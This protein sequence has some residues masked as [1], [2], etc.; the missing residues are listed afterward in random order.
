LENAATPQIIAPSVRAL[1][2]GR[3]VHDLLDVVRREPGLF[4]G[5][6]ETNTMRQ[7]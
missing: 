5:E 4:I 7:W 3:D 6:Q 2:T 1:A